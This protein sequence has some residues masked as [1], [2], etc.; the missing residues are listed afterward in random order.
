M[1]LL[2]GS[3]AREFVLKVVADVKDAV[4]GVQ[5]VGDQTTSMKDKMIGIGKG[6]AAGLGSAAVI[7]FGTDVIN[8]AADAD[9]ANDAIQAAFGKSADEISK[10][11]KSAADNMGMSSRDYQT[12]AAKTGNLLQ[13]MGI[14]SDQA[15]KS[16]EILSQRAADMAA[17]WGTDTATAMEAINKGLGGATK[18]LQ[19]FGVKIDAN[20]IQ[21][22]A[23]AKG[24]V[25]ASGK[26]TAA[27]K[28]IA[29]QELILEKTSNV[30]G[31]WA[32]NSKD[33]G[34]QQDILRAKMQDMQATIGEKL[35]PV[36]IKF[37]EML[38]PIATFLANNASWLAPIAAMIAGIV[39][40]IKAWTI[41]QTALNIVL[42]ANPLGLIVLAIAAVVAGIVLLYNKVDWFRAFV[43]G[44]MN[45]VV[46]VFQGFWDIVMAIYHWIAN[47]WPLIL[48]ILTGPIGAAVIVITKNWDTIKNGF[49]AAIDFI[50]QIA[51]TIWN[52]IT[53][54]FRRAI[55]AAKTI[56][57]EVPRA[58][59]SAVSGITNALSTVWSVIS[60]PFQDG[61]DKAKAAGEAVLSWFRGLYNAINGALSGVATVIRYPFETAFNAIKS[62]WN[63]TVGKISFTIPSWVPGIGGK[64]FSFPKMATGGIV[65]RPTIALVGEAGPEAVIPL[66]QMRSV[67]DVAGTVPTVINLNVYALTANAETG[68]RVYDSLREY[69]RISGTQLVIG[70]A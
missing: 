20:E 69:A 14:N 31:A 45:A 27:G 35:L 16:T 2:G 59:Q 3:G 58:F 49:K 4:E 37:M 65:T 68:R 52:I 22:R 54:P 42:S 7:K 19:Q 21:A 46:A 32:D 12:M 15:A 43:D 18:G 41:A 50:Q 6:V 28:A 67:N 40:A 51:G 23:M 17:I 39:V 26:V 55:D 5:K 11:S 53:F 66:N 34:S 36:V 29:A 1:S 38:Q 25:D 9:D 70:S 57:D 48:G 63:N 30:Q 44:A 13:S 61:W 56:V 8:A 47:N 10:F 24:Y 64:G 60:R 62:L 33:L